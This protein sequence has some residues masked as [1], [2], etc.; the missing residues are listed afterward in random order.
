MKKH[1]KVLMPNK[2]KKAE[3]QVMVPILYVMVLTA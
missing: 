1:D 3:A 2:C